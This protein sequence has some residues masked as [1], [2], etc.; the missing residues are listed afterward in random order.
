[1]NPNCEAE[2]PA[3]ETGGSAYV[4]RS[5]RF[6]PLADARR[7]L[8]SVEQ[9]RDSVAAVTGG[10]RG[11]VRFGVM[12]LQINA[13]VALALAGFHRD[14]PQVRLLLRTHPAGSAGLIQAVRDNKLDLAVAAVTPGQAGDVTLTPLRSGSMGL[15][16][17]PG[18]RRARR[19][20]VRLAE[21]AAEP[22]I[23]VTP[24]WGSRAS[25]DRLF[26][27]AGLPRQVDIEVG[28]VATVV[29]LVRAGLGA[30]LIAPS[31]APPGTGLPVI[32]PQPA[33]SFDVSLILPAARRSG[34]AARALAETVLAS[35]GHRTAAGPCADH[36][37]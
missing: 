17:P 31:S 19:K 21:L 25:T 18:H 5:A 6:L 9:A 3:D 33:P 32:Q 28:D 36:D 10:M 24:G 22:L 37:E 14:R 13:D 29:E 27:S 23:D 26:T 30:A 7:I 34:P 15:I 35:A 1:M 11:T 4:G 16:C 20:R 12:H 8:A 2:I